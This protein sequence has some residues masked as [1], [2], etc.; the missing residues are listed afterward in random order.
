VEMY[1]SKRDL[2]SFDIESAVRICRF[3][4]FDVKA[5]W[6]G[7]EEKTTNLVFF[8]E[9]PFLTFEWLGAL[10]VVAPLDGITHRRHDG[11][12]GGGGGG[13]DGFTF[14]SSLFLSPFANGDMLVLTGPGACKN[15]VGVGRVVL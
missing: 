1:V 9:T 6:R 13:G 15:T 14:L 8:E 12:F 4:G 3:A 2:L 10:F 11:E 7:E 5:F